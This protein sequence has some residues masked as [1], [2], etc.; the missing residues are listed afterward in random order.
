LKN[1]EKK[2]RAALKEVAVHTS[3]TKA[4]KPYWFEKFLWFITFVAFCI[5]TV[6]S[7][8]CRSEHYLVIG[9]RDRQQNELLVRR[10]L[11]KGDF[12]SSLLLWFRL[13]R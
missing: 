5:S 8:Q 6:E 1:T 4:R 11:K 10:Y 13:T 7:R 3:I 9:G 2:T 12:P